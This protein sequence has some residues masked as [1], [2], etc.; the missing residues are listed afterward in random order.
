MVGFGMI[1]Y[2]PCYGLQIV[3][4]MKGV[5]EVMPWLA[6]H[7]EAH[8]RWPCGDIFGWWWWGSQITSGGSLGF[9]TTVEC[10]CVFLLVGS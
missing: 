10:I 3:R 7:F 8:W 5:R 9:A 2:I 4:C 6:P 1:S